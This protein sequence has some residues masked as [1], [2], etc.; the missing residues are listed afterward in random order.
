MEGSSIARSR[1]SSA[2][3][4]QASARVEMETG[5]TR[6]LDTWKRRYNYGVSLYATAV[7]DIKNPKKV[8]A[9][10]KKDSNKECEP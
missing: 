7:S 4:K 8:F 9:K 5:V 10:P 2:R 3:L 6:K 1:Q